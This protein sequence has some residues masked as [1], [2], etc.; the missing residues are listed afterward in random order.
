[1][2]Q[3]IAERVQKVIAKHLRVETDKVPL[4]ATFEQLGMDSLDGVNLLFEVEDEFD[5]SIDD[6]DAKSI[7]SVPEMADGIEKL[8]ARKSGRDR[9]GPSQHMIRVAITGIGVISAIGNNVS[10]FWDSL[11]QG[12]SGIRPIEAPGCG[13]LRFPNGAEVPG[14]DPIAHFDEKQVP[15]VDRF[16]QFA[17]IAAREAVRDASVGVDARL[18]VR[19][20]G[21]YRSVRRRAEYFRRRLRQSVQAGQAAGQS[22]DDSSH[23]GQCRGEPHL[24]GIWAHWAG[25]QPVDGLLV[26]RTRD[27]TGVLDGALGRRS[28]WPLP[29]AARRRSAWAS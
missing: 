9:T 18:A 25:V 28:A 11:Q 6:Q 2:N 19:R 24:D 8:L 29:E 4:D 14:Y 20:S 17:V 1:M 23:H 12:Q 13:E 27:R 3:E 7:T 10:E 16:A 15:F 5:V 26:G 22:A 21:D